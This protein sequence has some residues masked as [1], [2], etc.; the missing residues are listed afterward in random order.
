MIYIVNLNTSRSATC[1]MGLPETRAPSAPSQTNV[2]RSSD[3]R[4]P[5][6][7]C[8][9]VGLRPGDRRKRR[10]RGRPT[11]QRRPHQPDSGDRHS[12]QLSC[13]ADAGRGQA[14]EGGQPQGL[15]RPGLQPRQP[16]RP[17]RS[18]D[19]P[20]RA[21]HLRR[22]KRR[23]LRPS[24]RR[25]AQRRRGGGV[26][27]ARRDAEARLQGHARAGHRL[28]Q[29][30]PAVRR[31]P[32]RD[33]RL[34]AGAPAPRADLHPG[35]DQDPAANSRRARNGLRRALHGRGA[36]RARRGNSLGVC[37]DGDDHA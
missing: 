8:G 4:V 37:R 24:V 36:G 35:G 17:A 5:S 22:R 26:R 27:S 25:D 18:W 9:I 32:R 3:V 16:D 29:Q 33:S 12:Q 2:P 7:H 15:R 23:P 11:R 1:H 31:L 19:P 10:R 34:V 30:L 28:C 6:C 14:A 20:G 21:R 13:R